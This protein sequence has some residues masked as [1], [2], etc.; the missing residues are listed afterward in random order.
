MSTV[1]SVVL[2]SLSIGC[3]TVVSTDYSTPHDCNDIG[4]YYGKPT[5]YDGVYTV[6]VGREETPLQV[7]CDMNTDGGGWTVC[8][9]AQHAKVTY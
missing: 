5:M 3:T 7:Y 8:I 1:T 6:Y 9:L 4:C 2:M